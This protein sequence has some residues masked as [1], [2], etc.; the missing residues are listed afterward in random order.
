MKAIVIWFS[1]TGNTFFVT[2]AFT[3]GLKDSGIETE[4]VSAETF[5]RNELNGYDIIIFAGPIF[6]WRFPPT[7]TKIIKNL[8]PNSLAGK[9]VFSIA[10]YGGIKGNAEFFLA[11]LIKSKGGKLLAV[12][13]VRCEDN[14]PSLRHR[15]TMKFIKVGHPDERDLEISKQVGYELGSHLQGKRKLPKS[16]KKPR[17]KLWWALLDPIAHLWYSHPRIWFKLKLDPDRCIDCG[18]CWENCPSGAIKINDKTLH[19]DIKVC[20]L[21]LRCVNICPV[22]ALNLPLSKNGLKY[23]KKGFKVVKTSQKE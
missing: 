15:W 20:D 13:G 5:K 4:F 23:W 9:K 22:N 21:C 2:K 18:L 19:H 11:K 17:Y 16:M 6:A 8:K 10:T 7:I 14:H 3:E 1:S 12:F